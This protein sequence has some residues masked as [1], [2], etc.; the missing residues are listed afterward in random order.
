MD[1]Y[2][3]DN[4]RETSQIFNDY[5]AKIG[6]FIAK[7]AKTKN[8]KAD[9]KTFLNNSVSQSIVLELPQLIEISNIINSLNV[10]KR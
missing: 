7:K 10:K 9:F 5:F 8:H 2:E 3:T 6:E 4:R 1:S